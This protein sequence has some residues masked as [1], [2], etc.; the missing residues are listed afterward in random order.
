[1]KVTLSGGP[2][3]GETRDLPWN[4]LEHLETPSGQAG[5]IWVHK[6]RR[7]VRGAQTLK[8]KGRGDPG[9]ISA[10]PIKVGWW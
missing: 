6:Y 4:A 2:W 10:P 7:A 3:D 5:V 1:M 8:Y 9:F